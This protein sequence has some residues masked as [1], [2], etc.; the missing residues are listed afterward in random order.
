MSTRIETT[1][2]L[3]SDNA[4]QFVRPVTIRL[5]LTAA[6]PNTR[7]FVFFDGVNLTEFAA[8]TGNQPGTIIRSDSAGQAVIDVNIPG[9]RFAPGDKEIIV[10]DTNDLANLDTCLLYTSPSP[11]DA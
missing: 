7:M 1:R 6:R 4:V 3:V 10:T 9:G 5:T 8:I 2:T 11:R